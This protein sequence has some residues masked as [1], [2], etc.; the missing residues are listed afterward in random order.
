LRD[1]RRHL[2]VVNEYLIK[3][4]LEQST[5]TVEEP[6]IITYHTLIIQATSLEAA[7]EEVTALVGEKAS[8]PYVVKIEHTAGG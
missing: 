7:I 6:T 1:K 3:C 2:K 5:G 8:Y 4:R